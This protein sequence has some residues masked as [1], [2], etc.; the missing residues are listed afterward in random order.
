[1][2]GG[3]GATAYLAMDSTSAD[4]DHEPIPAYV[5][6]SL[7]RHRDGSHFFLGYC[8]DI[9]LTDPMRKTLGKKFDAVMDEIVGKA[10]KQVAKLVDP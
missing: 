8:S 10:G 1:M 3:A 2:G 6:Y 7:V 5:A 4:A 9:A